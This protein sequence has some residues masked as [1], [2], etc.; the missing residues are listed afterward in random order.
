M[1]GSWGTICDDDFDRADAIVICRILGYPRPERAIAYSNAHYGQG[2]VT[3]LIRNLDCNGIEVNIGQCDPSFD[4]SSHCDHSE[5]SS[6]DCCPNCGIGG[7]I[8][9]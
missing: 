8:I 5:D 2:N 4:A 3:V 6:V 9:G 1:G 7:Q